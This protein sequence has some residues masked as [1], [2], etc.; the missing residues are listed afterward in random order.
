MNSD[1]P[2]VS[3]IIPLYNGARYI[4]ETLQSV[5]NQSHGNFEIVVV[6]DGSKD[7]S[8][9]IVKAIS[10]PRIKYTSQENKGIAGARNTGIKLSRGEYIT[11]LDQ[12]DLFHREKL[13]REVDAFKQ[14]PG[15]GVVYSEV[16]AINEHRSRLNSGRAMFHKRPSGNVLEQSLAHNIIPGTAGIMVLRSCF[17]E[18]G[19]FDEQL[20]GV[21]DWHMWVRLAAVTRFKYLP[22]EHAFV[23]LHS[24]N[25]S[26]DVSHMA[27][28][29]LAAVDKL[30]SDPLI[31][32]AAS[33]LDVERLRKLSKASLNAYCGTRTLVT[34]QPRSAVPYF[35]E[36]IRLRPGSGREWILLA[37]AVIGV[38]PEWVK[39]R[40]L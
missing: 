11:F 16:P 26:N 13:E 10:D 19:L 14:H 3:V 5:L 20:S 21:D 18:A 8:A 40:L 31:R 37:I 1:D 28:D 7:D 2:L 4:S 32:S 25:T 23:R 12:D 22:E 38:V 17:D 33:G 34:A 29:G 39:Q 15:V 9:E 30:Y 24:S 6:D 36:A 35:R 27:R